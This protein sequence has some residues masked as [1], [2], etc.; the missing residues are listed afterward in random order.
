MALVS[1]Q[2][3]LLFLGDLARYK[4]QINETHCF[5]R[6]KSWY[7][8][9]QQIQPKNGR[10]YNQLAVLSIYSVIYINLMYFIFCLINY[11]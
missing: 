8:K 9:A 1:A 5:G 2:K 4:E 6:A 10:P 7:V 11:F 3:L